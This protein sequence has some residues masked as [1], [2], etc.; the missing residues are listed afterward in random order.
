MK[1]QNLVMPQSDLKDQEKMYFRLNRRA[2]LANCHQEVLFEK[3]GVASLDTYFNS[4]SF[5]KWR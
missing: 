1:L 3:G 5:E 4:L 2:R